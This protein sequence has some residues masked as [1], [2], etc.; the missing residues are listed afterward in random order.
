MSHPLRLPGP[1]PADEG[2]AAAGRMQLDGERIQGQPQGAAA[3]IPH[4]R[5]ASPAKGAPAAGAAARGGRATHPLVASALSLTPEQQQALLAQLPG[6]TPEALAA[7]QAALP[8]G[9]DGQPLPL[10]LPVLGPGG[11]GLQPLLLD[12]SVLLSNHPVMGPN[13]EELSQEQ[14][15]WRDP[16]A[17]GSHPA[18]ACAPGH[19]TA[20]LRRP[21]PLRFPAR[22]GC[23]PPCLHALA[24]ACVC[25]PPAPSPLRCPPTWPRALQLSALL[26]SAA[27]MQ[28]IIPLAPGQALP[29]GGVV[30]ADARQLYKSWW[31]P[32]EEKVG[33]GW[34]ALRAATAPCAL[35]LLSPCRLQ[36]CK[37][38]DGPLK[39]PWAG[40][41]APA[42]CCCLLRLPCPAA[43]W[44]SS[45]LCRSRSSPHLQELL[46]LVEDPQFREEKFGARELDW[47]RI[48]AHFGGRRCARAPLG[49][50]QGLPRAGGMAARGACACCCTTA[51]G[52]PPSLP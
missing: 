28:F 7:A 32:Q 51:A 30:G 17:G 23:T 5:A 13:G 11:E 36:T 25:R 47:G 2:G 39:V 42:A 18:A 12:P 6:V 14:V 21:A 3:G 19:A 31:D 22:P 43:P 46:Q 29:A 48:E 10:A 20:P 45:L 50:R 41:A 37:A 33:A 52:P 27:Q 16:A 24:G 40:C 44:P 15:R 9:P 4:G 38:Q 8:A 1:L 26:A 35:C 49:G 34:E